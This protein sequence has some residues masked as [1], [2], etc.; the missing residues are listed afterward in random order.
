MAVFSHD[1]TERKTAEERL[2]TSLKEK[3]VLLRELYHRTKNNM[4]VI[5]SML[6]LYS[7]DFDDETVKNVFSELNNKIRTMALVHQKLYKSQNLSCI[8]MKEYIRELVE[9]LMKSYRASPQRITP[10]YDLDDIFFAID[11]AIPCGLLVNELISNA[12]KHAFPG[13][14]QGRITVRLKKKEGEYVELQVAD[15]GIGAPS[16]FDFKSGGKMGLQTVF[17]LGGHQLQG[18]I[19]FESSAGVTCRVIFK[20]KPFT[21]QTNI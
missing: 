16:E 17:A 3:E 4:Q 12:L 21:N 15:D 18:K 14:R 11:L 9:L 10:E 19:E 1:I 7:M 2:I 13:S 20:N 6:E 8:G 5:C